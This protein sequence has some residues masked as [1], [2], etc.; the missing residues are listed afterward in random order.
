[1]I[2][3]WEEDKL[4]P[5]QLAS[6][7]LTLPCSLFFK[8]EDNIHFVQLIAEVSF[9]AVSLFICYLFIRMT[10]CPVYSARIY[11]LKNKVLKVGILG[12]MSF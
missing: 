5:V 6:I 12:L 2:E 7:L 9:V 1:M 8:R 11:L 10:I 4:S 3:P